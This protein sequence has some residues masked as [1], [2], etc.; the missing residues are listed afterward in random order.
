M[1]KLLLFTLFLITTT[2]S[3]AQSQSGMNKEANQAFQKADKELNDTYKK[4][5]KEYSSDAKFIKNFKAAQRL[6]VQFRDAEMKAK[7]PEEASNYGSVLP[8]CWSNALIQLTEERTK[9]INVWLNGTQ[10]GDTCAGSV[11]IK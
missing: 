3:F 10:E 6:W 1:Q 7:F 8:L 4:V 2:L 9:A 11:K 5:L